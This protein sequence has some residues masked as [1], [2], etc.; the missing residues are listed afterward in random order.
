MNLQYF[1]KFCN[2]CSNYSIWCDYNL[3]VVFV[4]KKVFL[5]KLCLPKHFL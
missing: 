4:Y 1:K 2:T 5:Q 3:E